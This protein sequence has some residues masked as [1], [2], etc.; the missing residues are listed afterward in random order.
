MNLSQIEALITDSRFQELKYRQER[1]NVFNIVGQTHTEHWHS[2]FLSWLFDPHSSLGLGH[3]PLARLLNQYLIK[4]TETSITLKELF[5]YNLNDVR[6]VTEKTCLISDKKRSI[7]VYGESDE[8]IIVI[9]NKVAARENYN[10]TEVGQTKDYYDYVE[11][12]KTEK[13]KVFYFFITAVPSQKAYDEHYV[14]ITYQ[15]LYDNIIA[16]CICHPQLHEESKYLLEQYASNLREPV[17]GSPMA[18]VN[19][20]VCKEIYEDYTAELDEIFT[21]VNSSIEIASSSDL[22]CI[23]YNR[24]GKIFDEIYLS[25]ENYGNTPKS[26]IK[27][28]IVTF[29]DMYRAGVVTDGMPFTMEYDGVTYYAKAAVARNKKECFLQVLDENRQAY[30]DASGEIVGTYESSSK[31]GV[32]VINLYR[33]KHNIQPKVATLRGTIYWKNQDGKTVKDLIDSM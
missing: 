12:N 7:D 24:Y 4:K 32:D 27:R 28:Q 11:Q 23:I 10:G 2:S 22:A 25:V 26:G 14:Q 8:V 31:A 21:K 9:E 13:Q 3:F 30:K 17:H 33:K 16:K 18:L 29:T 15:E 19:I 5:A 20:D 1:S 6:F